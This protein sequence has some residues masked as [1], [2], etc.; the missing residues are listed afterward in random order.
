VN[1]NNSS[2][3]RFGLAIRQRRHEL[4]ISQEELAEKS[5]LHRTYIS[6][7]ERGSRNPSLESIERLAKALEI[8]ISTLF[9]NYSFEE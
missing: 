3:T 8:K 1:K 7:I 2:A 5:D 4:A 6:D 9:A